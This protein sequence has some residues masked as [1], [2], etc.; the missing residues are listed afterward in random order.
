ME[1]VITYFPVVWISRISFILEQDVV[2][3]GAGCVVRNIVRNTMISLQARNCQRQ[4]II[5]A[6]AVRKKLDSKRKITV[7]E[8][9]IHIA[10]NDGSCSGLNH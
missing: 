5:T 1:H 2:V 7:L 10:R 9:I 3:H 4:K 6:S 8:D